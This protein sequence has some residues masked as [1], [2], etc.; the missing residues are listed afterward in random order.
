[1]APRQLRL[2][3]I[4]ADTAADKGAKRVRVD[5]TEES[6]TQVSLRARAIA[7]C[8]SWLCLAQCWLGLTTGA[9]ASALALAR[10]GKCMQ[11]RPLR[12]SQHPPILPQLRLST[13]TPSGAPASIDLT[14][15]Y[16]CDPQM[17][18]TS[19]DPFKPTAA[20]LAG[21]EHAA[22]AMDTSASASGRQAR[23][24][25]CAPRAARNT[26]TITK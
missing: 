24:R 14:T 1:M 4:E 19:F 23:T 7:W 17:V 12:E 6:S 3:P 8:T 5:S 16:H 18:T 15:T 26:E 11:Q 13:A 21:D 2:E 22:G 25:H 10:H 9:R 20:E